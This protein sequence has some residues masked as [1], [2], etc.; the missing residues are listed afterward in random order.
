MN[1]SSLYH[2]SSVPSQPDSLDLAQAWLV[3]NEFAIDTILDFNDDLIPVSP[4]LTRELV[5][6]IDKIVQSRDFSCLEP[7][8]IENLTLC[9]VEASQRLIN[10]TRIVCTLLT[11]LTILKPEASRN[12]FIDP[13]SKRN[14]F[15][16]N[17]FLLLS[18]NFAFRDGN[19]FIGLNYGK[20]TPHF[21]NF[22]SKLIKEPA[23]RLTT[24]F[25]SLKH[26]P[27]YPVLQLFEGKAKLKQSSLEIKVQSAIS[28]ASIHSPQLIYDL[29]DLT[30]P[31]QLNPIKVAPPPNTVKLELKSKLIQ[32]SNNPNW[33]D[34][35]NRRYFNKSEKEFFL[36]LLTTQLMDPFTEGD[37][38]VRARTQLVNLSDEEVAKLYEHL[39][40]P[41]FVQNM[42]MMTTLFSPLELSKCDQ[43][44]LTEFLFTFYLYHGSRLF[45]LDHLIKILNSIP[46]SLKNSLQEKTKGFSEMA[47]ISELM[48]NRQNLSP[49]TQSPLSSPSLPTVPERPEIS[50]ADKPAPIT[51][52]PS[53]AP[54]ISSPSS[55]VSSP[56][57]QLRTPRLYT[58][59]DIRNIQTKYNQSF[60]R[61]IL[62]GL[63]NLIIDNP[64]LYQEMSAILFDR[65]KKTLLESNLQNVSTNHQQA[66]QVH[67]LVEKNLNFEIEM[68]RDVL[69]ILLNF[70]NDQLGSE[71]KDRYIYAMALMVKYMKFF[72]ISL[73]SLP[74]TSKSIAYEGR[75]V[76]SYIRER[77]N[78]AEKNLI[79]CLA[80]ILREEKH[81]QKIQSLTPA[82]VIKKEWEELIA[83]TLYAL[84][85][86]EAQEILQN[87]K[88]LSNIQSQPMVF[89]YKQDQEI[90][91]IWTYAEFK[92][93]QLISIQKISQA[94]I[95]QAYQDIF[96][97]ALFGEE[98]ISLSLGQITAFT[99]VLQ[100][101]KDLVLTSCL[102]RIPSPSKNAWAK[103]KITRRY[104]GLD[105]KADEIANTNS[106]LLVESPLIS[107]QENK[108]RK[109]DELE[110]PSE[111]V[112][113]SPAP[114]RHKPDQANVVPMDTA[115][116]SAPPPASSELW[117]QIT[118]KTYSALLSDL[119]S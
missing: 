41:I 111:S 19:S 30:L 64:S 109:R 43:V 97:N 93:N 51:S 89:T 72:N 14:L 99:K 73:T 90:K 74:D 46:V 83:P 91:C 106:P 5:E 10:E 69:E 57:S 68:T 86:Q 103:Q 54:P 9:R 102:Q 6:I 1:V 76:L 26:S 12:Q 7:N 55:A 29:K 47:K 117:T 48:A 37:N 34:F 113:N 116:E 67:H 115:Q 71:N 80:N 58:P 78:K 27:L 114:K 2:H 4:T 63:Q 52:S 23:F 70:Y 81:N 108:K 61:Q 35:F 42:K 56:Q 40:D 21:V 17:S 79:V 32:R 53:S 38:A 15:Y 77:K 45:E 87:G 8:F 82:L 107:E 20:L 84:K 11:L 18:F 96:P 104:I 118:K 100:E 33:I 44:A 16:E 13:S 95:P 112:E 36:K 24:F 92:N 59:E 75:I 25:S 98:A 28:H 3:K 85:F 31:S 65:L 105:P 50:E 88:A 62:I 39:D 119:Y 110:S 22:I 101:R 66:I 94:Q 60:R 49:L